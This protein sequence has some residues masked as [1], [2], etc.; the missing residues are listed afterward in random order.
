MNIDDAKDR[1]TRLRNNPECNLSLEPN[2]VSSFVNQKESELVQGKIKETLINLANLRLKKGS[3][4]SDDP[5]SQGDIATCEGIEAFLIPAVEGALSISDFLKDYEKGAK[6]ANALVEDINKLVET[7]ESKGFEGR[8]YF[9]PDALKRE[10][11]P[12][13]RSK[14][15]SLNTT[16]SAAI[17][18]RVIIHLLNLHLNRA[19]EEYF[20]QLIGKK[21]DIQHLENCLSKAVTF[22]VDAFQKGDDKKNPIGSAMTEG[23]PGSG[24]SWTDWPGLP[25]MLFFTSAAV[26]AFAELELYLIRKAS[27]GVLDKTLNDIYKKNE[28]KLLEYQFC[29]DMARQWVVNL[30]LPNISTGLGIYVEKDPTD[31]TP[32]DFDDEPEGYKSYKLDLGK[33]KDLEQ[34]PIVFYNN[35]YALLI[36]LWSFGDWDDSGEDKNMKSKSMIERALMQ[37]VNNYTRI[38]V[39]RDILNRFPYVFYLPGK[40]YFQKKESNP[41][42]AYMDSGFLT[43]LTRQLVLCGVYGLGDP[44]VLNPL[45]ESLYIELLL[46]RYREEADYAYLWS[47]KNKEIFSTQRAVQALTFYCAYAKGKEFGRKEGREGLITDAPRGGTVPIQLELKIPENFDW[48]AIFS[49]LES[50]INKSKDKKK[51]PHET[52]P[53]VTAKNFTEYISEKNVKIARAVTDTQMNFLADIDKIGNEINDDFR[54]GRIP[55]K[56]T[57]ELLDSLVELVQKPWSKSGS[58]LSKELDKIKTKYQKQ[59]PKKE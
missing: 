58:P 28:T 46:N 47:I 21:F 35:L 40:G 22:L 42:R 24:W 57:V 33:M 32:I 1:W 30:V 50:L 25:P 55:Y 34:F 38:D 7:W 14:T 52:Q 36:L 39:I 29:V 48:N 19:D 13:T 31:G 53:T 23:M 6:F 16:E 49:R 41:A 43:L 17:A 12:V 11:D 20:S 2:Y 44:N 27:I 51:N 8:P 15:E 59:V 18:S 10:L 37:V 9:D 26:D 56:N 4:V 3:F 5:P 45:I 54:D